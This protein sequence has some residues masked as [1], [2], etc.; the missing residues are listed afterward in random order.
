[1]CMCIYLLFFARRPLQNLT[2]KDALMKDMNQGVR[3][4]ETKGKA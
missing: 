4:A 2:E 1:M 3:K